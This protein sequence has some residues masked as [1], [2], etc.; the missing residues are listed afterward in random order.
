MGLHITFYCARMLLKPWNRLWMPSF[1]VH[2]KCNAAGMAC[3]PDSRLQLS[4]KHLF[5][6]VHKIG[7]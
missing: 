1:G 7:M 6:A 4:A 2:A 3:C 5:H